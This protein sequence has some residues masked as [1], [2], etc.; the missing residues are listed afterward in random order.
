ML[1][2]NKCPCDLNY[3]VI[4]VVTQCEIRLLLNLKTETLRETISLWFY[5]L[6]GLEELLISGLMTISSFLPVC[7]LCR[8]QQHDVPSEIKVMDDLCDGMTKKCD[9]SREIN[10]LRIYALCV[11]T[12][13]S[14]FYW[15]VKS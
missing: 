11:I 10:S 9:S 2:V 12:Y 4:V 3:N 6:V 7:S 14:M 1:K 15:R 13:V 5:F 8:P